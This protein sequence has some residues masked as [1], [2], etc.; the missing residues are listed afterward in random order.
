MDY[1]ELPG[2]GRT[3]YLKN[4]YR[5]LI[6]EPI[7][8]P[9]MNN[10]IGITAVGDFGAYNYKQGNEKIKIPAIYFENNGIDGYY[11]EIK[12]YAFWSADQGQES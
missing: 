2:D 9:L 11:N 4:K 3:I 1:F 12:D 8:L 7:T 5:Y 10:N 6:Q